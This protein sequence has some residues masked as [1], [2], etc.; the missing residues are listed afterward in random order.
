[1][2]IFFCRWPNG[3]CSLVS[4][5]AK[6]EAIERLDEVANAEGCPITQVEHLQVHFTLTDEGQPALD[7]LGEAMEDEVFEFCYPE[8]EQA[9]ADGD[10]LAVA[11]NRERDRVQ[12]AA[13][14]AP[15]T[16]LGQRA[17][18]ELDMPTTLVDRIVSTAAKQRLKSFK[19]R[20]NPS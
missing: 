1:M 12:V 11:V 17:K 20:G 7:G 4:A 8:L 18:R 15:Q 3:D 13:V 14:K 10:D 9:L 6:A 2:P 16:E 5:R 19:P